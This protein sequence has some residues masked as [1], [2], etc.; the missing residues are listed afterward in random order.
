ML[1]ELIPRGLTVKKKR[2]RLNETA[3]NTIR[4][5]IK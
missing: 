1:T 4:R 2:F 3:I 5:E